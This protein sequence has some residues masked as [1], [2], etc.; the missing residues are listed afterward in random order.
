MTPDLHGP[1]HPPA[2]SQNPA[3][4]TKLFVLDTNVLMH[5]PTSL[6]RFE[7]HDIFVPIMT[8]EELDN[9][10]KGMS[11]VPRNARQ[12]SRCSTRSSA[13]ED[14][15]EQ[16]IR[17]RPLEA[18][19]PAAACSCRPKRSTAS[20][21]RACRRQGRQPDPRGRDAPLSRTA[22][23]ASG[24]PGVEGHQHAHQGAR[25][26]AGR[27]RTTSTTRCS[28]TPTC[29]TPARASCR[30]LLGRARQGIE[31]WKQDG[32]TCTGQGPACAPI[33]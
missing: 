27:R 22:P 6:F 1:Q 21:R 9:N 3:A 14:S 20:C 11:E 4:T 24:D 13:A 12:V 8:L 28:K 17:W 32:R 15:I 19:W 31:S 23:G 5:D 10:K 29:S 16:G 18:N 26:R 30:R 7:E 33:C 2:E 25:A